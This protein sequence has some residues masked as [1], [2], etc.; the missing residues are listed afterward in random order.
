MLAE[1]AGLDPFDGSGK[2]PFTDLPNAPVE[3][4]H[5]NT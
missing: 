5:E 2:K 3:A 1:V 4:A